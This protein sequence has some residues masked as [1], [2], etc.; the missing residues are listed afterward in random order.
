MAPG[1]RG[2]TS[3]ATGGSVAFGGFRTGG[4]PFGS[5]GG[6]APIA[7]GGTPSGGS[8]T[9]GLPSGG[10]ASGGIGTGGRAPSGGTPA[11][12]G[13]APSATGGVGGTDRCHV[14]VARTP[15]WGDANHSFLSYQT[16]E[17]NWASYGACPVTFV[18][19]PHEFSLAT[20][21]EVG[22]HTLWIPDPAGAED[23]YSAAELQ[24]VT[25]WV[26]GGYG[27]LVGTFL[28]ER[29]L[30]SLVTDNG[31]LFAHFGIDQTGVVMTGTS[32]STSVSR[33]ALHPVLSGLT[34]PFTIASYA[35]A[36]AVAVDWPSVLLSGAVIVASSNDGKSVVVARDAPHRSVYVSTFPEY[37]AGDSAR[38]LVYDAAMWTAGRD[39]W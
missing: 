32:A 31:P 28:L 21:L 26:R 15:G 37:Q 6:L 16:I 19:I 17:K 24:A 7:T 3:S 12:T 22:P 35:E 25:D 27:G 8:S 9:G 13:G 38:Q 5:T 39:A 20:I 30:A 29:S 2:G 18:D 1:N 36:Q 4:A 11:L 10:Q 33:L 34:D 23:Q 14:V